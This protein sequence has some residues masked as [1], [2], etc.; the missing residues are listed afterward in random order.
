MNVYNLSKNVFQSEV[1]E[2]KKHNVEAT[3]FYYKA[4]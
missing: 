4:V 1:T 3:C 2:F